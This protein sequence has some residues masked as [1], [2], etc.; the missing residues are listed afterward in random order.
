MINMYVIKAVYISDT[1]MYIVYIVYMYIIH[2]NVTELADILI[3]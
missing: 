2:A 3:L 1:L